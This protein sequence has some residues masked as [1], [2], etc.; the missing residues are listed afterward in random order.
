MADRSGL[1]LSKSI[2]LPYFFIEGD[3]SDTTARILDEELSYFVDG[4]EHTKRYQKGYWNG[5]E[6]LLRRTKAGDYYFPV[7]VLSNVTAVLDSLDIDYTIDDDFR[8]INYL[9][10][11][12]PAKKL[13]EYQQDALIKAVANMSG[14]ICLPT[15]SGKTLVGIHLMHA[16]NCRTLICVHTKELFY[17]WKDRVS[18]YLDYEPGLVGD[19]SEIWKDITIAMIQTANKLD[20]PEFDMLIF[21]EVHRV[22]SSTAYRL[23]MKCN[24]SLRYGLSA[25]P[26]REDGADLKIWAATGPIIVNVSPEDLVELG[27]LAKPRFVFLNPPY[28]KVSKNNWQTEYNEGVV[29]NVE[30]NDMI[31]S[32]AKRLID[33]GR[34]VYIHVVRISHGKKLSEMIDCPFISGKDKTSHRQ[35]II[36]KFRDGE[37]KCLVSTLLGEGVDIPSMDAIIMAHGQKTSVGTIQKIGR[38]LRTTKD[39]KEAIIVDFVDKGIYLS[40]HWENRYMAYEKAYGNYIR[41]VTDV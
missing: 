31:A 40:R 22:P 1:V 12:K 34:Q 9:G 37:I 28:V 8:P 4:Y 2:N 11:Q 23:A 26:Q 32:K 39:K 16:F 5:K 33:E 25:T 41:G 19:G 30:R 38:V 15:G 3:V 6:R 36:N 18:K 20:I 7:G 13:Y 21:D 24:A 14:V 27:Y 17:Q 10:I 35:E 29:K